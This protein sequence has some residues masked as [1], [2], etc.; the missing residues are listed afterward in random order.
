MYRYRHV[1]YIYIYIH[2]WFTYL[3]M[4]MLQATR[5]FFEAIRRALRPKASA[6]ERLGLPSAVCEA[7]HVPLKEALKTGR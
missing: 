7:P 4:Y 5:R 2:M 6:F 3:C 1:I